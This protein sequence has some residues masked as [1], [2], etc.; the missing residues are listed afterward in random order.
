[1]WISESIVGRPDVDKETRQLA[2][3]I[4][5]QKIGQRFPVIALLCASETVFVQ[6][7][8]LLRWGWL[9]ASTTSKAHQDH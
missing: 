2:Q 4:S 5:R 7:L 3:L 8:G 9:G 6:L 1:L